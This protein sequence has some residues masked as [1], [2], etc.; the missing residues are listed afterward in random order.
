VRMLPPQRC[1]LHLPWLAHLYAVCQTVVREA[2]GV[3]EVVSACSYF[4]DIGAGIMLSG[5]GAL[6][7]L[8]VGS[9]LYHGW[10][11]RE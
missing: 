1:R 5:I 4:A 6:I 7:W 9:L 8:I 11:N 2:D 10:I 3:E